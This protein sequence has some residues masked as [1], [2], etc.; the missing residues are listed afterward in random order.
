MARSSPR[1]SITPEGARDRL[2][3]VPEAADLLRLSTRKINDLLA[4]GNLR[5]IKI[6]RATRIQ[7]TELETLIRE[8]TA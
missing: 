4:A 7:L 1:S 2:V 8:G 6:G 5:R 3:T